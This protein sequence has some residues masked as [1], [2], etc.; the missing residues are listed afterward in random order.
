MKSKMNQ[1]MGSE[2]VKV[3]T[4]HKTVGQNIFIFLNNLEAKLVFWR[5][6]CKKYFLFLKSDPETHYVK[7]VCIFYLI[8][9]FSPS[10]GCNETNT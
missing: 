2:I 1:H 5:L 7:R 4:S 8:F 9:Y 10:K 3:K 6:L